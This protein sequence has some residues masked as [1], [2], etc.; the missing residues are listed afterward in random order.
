MRRVA[1]A[2]IIL[3]SLVSLVSLT[4][5]P[6]T[7]ASS[8]HPLTVE[9]TITYKY[10]VQIEG[11][12][13]PNSL[14]RVEVYGIPGQTA[15]QQVQATPSDGRIEN[16]D[17]R[18][19]W[20]IE[21]YGPEWYTTNT[22]QATFVVRVDIGN[23]PLVPYHPLTPASGM[24]AYLSPDNY[25]TLSSE[26]V[27]QAQ[28]LVS[29]TDNYTIEI[30]TKF[31]DWIK[32][33]I[34]YSLEVGHDVKLTDA[35]VLGLGA[36]VCDEF[37]TLF[38]GFCRSVG[39]P[40]RHVHGYGARGEPT[41][42]LKDNAHCWAEVWIPDYGWLTVDPTWADIGNT[43]RIATNKKYGESSYYWYTN[44][45]QGTEVTDAKLSSIILTR[46][47]IIDEATKPVTLAKME[48]ENA[49]RVTV[50]NDAPIPLLDNVTIKKMVLENGNWSEWSVVFNE[51]IFLNPQETC[52]YTIP[53]EDGC[54]YFVR[55]RMAE[56]SV[57]MWQYPQYPPEEYPSEVFLDP[58][59]LAILIVIIV[60]GVIVG[61]V[62]KK[63]KHKR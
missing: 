34:T 50:K 44:V 39:I 32:K 30:V 19:V 60:I 6:T 36:G 20:V 9:Y 46:K 16:I 4:I 15:H 13:Y 43:E 56:N 40:S 48:E 10:E 12:Y 18:E 22:F 7:A 47:T 35:Q 24:D 17:G 29:E 59:I 33:N 51:M 53:K 54:G 21:K 3:V 28:Q 23:T 1:T 14:L 63:R 8:S 2:F 41:L 38:I 45:P 42:D 37:S 49:W 52:T 61:T 11:S 26:V 62:M 31:V 25:V 57:S 58:E 27:N 5:P 55:S